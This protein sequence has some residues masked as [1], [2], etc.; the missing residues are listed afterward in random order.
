MVDDPRDPAACPSKGPGLYSTFE[1][2]FALYQV[3]VVLL[4]VTFSHL[5]NLEKRRKS[6]R[7][8]RLR[9]KLADAMPFDLAKRRGLL[10]KGRSRWLLA[11]LQL[12]ISPEHSCDPHAF[13]HATC[14]PLDLHGSTAAACSGWRSH[15]ATAVRVLP[16]PLG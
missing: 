1:Y 8:R 10:D 4:W 12:Q 14:V 2:E 3:R 6:R 9:E 13:K 15:A 16:A 5:F 7:E 11:L